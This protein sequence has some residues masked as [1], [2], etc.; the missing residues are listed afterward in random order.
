MFLQFLVFPIA[1][2]RYGVLNCLKAMI[3]VFPVI[4]FVTPFTALVPESL[5][6]VTIFLL[7]LSK[8]A[9]S[10]FGFPCITILL[11]N[12]ATSLT[13]LGTLNGVATSVSAV[14]RAAGPAICGAAFSFGV[15]KGYIILP[16]WMLSIFGALSALPIYWT[17][18]PDGFQGNDAEEEQDEPQESDYGAADHR[19]SSGARTGN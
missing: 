19:R 6:H 15:K 10:I 17:V 14:G 16:W 5:R 9:A 2:K 8:L 1:A 3:L 11:T 13:V 7:M 4:Y 12:S 18:E